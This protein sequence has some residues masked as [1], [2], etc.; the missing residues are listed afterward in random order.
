[1]LFRSNYC[2]RN[3]HNCHRAYLK[4]Q[5]FIFATPMATIH[6]G[7]ALFW[8]HSDSREK[9]SYFHWAV[10]ATETSW[11]D[12]DGVQTYDIAPKPF[13]RHSR[14]RCLSR[15]ATQFHCT[16]VWSLTPSLMMETRIPA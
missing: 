1:M 16:D 3:K 9:D 4:G 13:A 15:K 5:T 8:I 6:L 12:G 2:W 10:V 7:I 14:T 11:T